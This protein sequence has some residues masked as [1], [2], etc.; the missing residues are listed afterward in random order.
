MPPKFKA[1]LPPWAESSAA[2]SVVGTCTNGT[3]RFKMLAT[4]PAKSPT[5]PPPNATITLA[6][7]ENA[8]IRPV[9]FFRCGGKA[10]TSFKP[11][12]ASTP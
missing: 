11:S 4:K 8:F 1:V 12:P 2:N 10:P 3:P 9:I 6:R 7:G 5:V